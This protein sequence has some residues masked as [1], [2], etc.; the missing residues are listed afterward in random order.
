MVAPGRSRLLVSLLVLASTLP[1]AG[2]SI[3]GQTPPP[4]VC[5]K[6]CLDEAVLNFKACA[7]GQ[8]SNLSVE[9][10]QRFE[11]SIARGLVGGGGVVELSKTVVETK[12]SDVALEIVRGC[13]EL[14]KNVAKPA[15]VGGINQ[16]IDTLQQ[17]LDQQSQGTIVLDPEHGPYGQVIHVTGANWGSNKELEISAGPSKVRATTKADGTFE[18]TIRLD[19][20]FEDVSGSSETIRV[21]PVKASTQFDASALYT[22]DK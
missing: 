3:G 7:E 22:I 16:Q 6:G 20:R 9:E 17:M 2:C 10:R 19:P 12:L 18:T 14:S 13:L 4:S 11:A 8:S 5:G 15:E 1:F 21:S